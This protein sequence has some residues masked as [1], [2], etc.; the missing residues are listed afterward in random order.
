MG[1][2]DRVLYI[3]IWFFCC[4]SGNLMCSIKI[5]NSARIYFKTCVEFLYDDYYIQFMLFN[6][7]HHIAIIASDIEKS[8][9][10]YVN[11]L[12]LKVIREIDRPER[13]SKV[14]LPILS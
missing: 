7:I 6:R 4:I 11:K 9:Y 10:F 8:K 1:G 13:K 2:E 14:R 5:S 3:P 12:G